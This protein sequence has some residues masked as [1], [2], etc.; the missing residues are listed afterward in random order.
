MNLV[1]PPARKLFHEMGLELTSWCF[2]AGLVSELWLR[3][4]P[5]P[6]GKREELGRGCAGKV[7]SCGSPDGG[8]WL[9]SACPPSLSLSVS[10]SVHR[11][12]YNLNLGGG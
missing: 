8:G 1:L 2:G 12:H 9:G 10:S 5:R 11:D 7:K 6:R 4:W 3:P